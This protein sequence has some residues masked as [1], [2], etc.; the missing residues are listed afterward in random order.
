M[1][2]IQPDRRHIARVP[3]VFLCW[4]DGG[5][6]DVEARVEDV[7]PDGSGLF[8]RTPEF[9]EGEKVVLLIQGARRQTLV[10]RG[11]IRWSSDESHIEGFGLQV[12]NAAEL[13]AFLESCGLN[14]GETAGEAG[15]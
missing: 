11:Q 9:P 14:P 7:S 3:R 5:Y 13:R 6:R 10:V 1:Q 15:S 4:F 8:V 12:E 2:S